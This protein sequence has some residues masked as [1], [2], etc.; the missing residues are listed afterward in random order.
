MMHEV[1]K[2]VTINPDL[3]TEDLC[4][5]YAK[6]S[7][8]VEAT[9]DEHFKQIHTMLHRLMPMT[10]SSRFN[11]ADDVLKHICFS[12]SPLLEDVENTYAKLTQDGT[13]VA[14]QRSDKEK[15]LDDLTATVHAIE[16]RIGH[17]LS[18][19]DSSEYAD[20]RKQLE[21]LQTSVAAY[22]KHCDAKN[23]AILDEPKGLALIQNI[24]DITETLLLIQLLNDSL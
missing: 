20:A 6:S 1:L 4:N 10:C 13:I 3:T 21:N 11:I 16:L 8:I 22:K 19:L 2:P 14:S 12:L 9:D 17:L 15:E 23:Y 18:A 5:L 7:Q 24:D